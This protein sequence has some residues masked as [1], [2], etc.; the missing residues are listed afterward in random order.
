MKTLTLLR[1]A[2]STWNDPVARDFDRPL[3]PRGR[4][5]ARTADALHPALPAQ[6]EG[7]RAR[8]G[9]RVGRREAHRHA[10]VVEVDL[11][12]GVEVPPL[13]PGQPG[14]RHH[15][16]RALG[17]LVDRV[18]EGVERAIASADA[19]LSTLL[20]MHHSER[21]AALDRLDAKASWTSKVK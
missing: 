1:H 5:A 2:K 9:R 12:G 16:R 4:R 11:A 7:G 6:R 14:L 18:I 17:A 13:E 20:D 8:L 21:A 3:N 19:R 10:A 15:R